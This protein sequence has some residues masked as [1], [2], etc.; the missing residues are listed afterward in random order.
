MIG[1]IEDY[2]AVQDEGVVPRH[3]VY[4]NIIDFFCLRV[5]LVLPSCA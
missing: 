1:A 5:L 4:S 3:D 2:A